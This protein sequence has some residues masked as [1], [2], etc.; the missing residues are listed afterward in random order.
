MIM[1]P[2]CGSEAATQ[3]YIGTR[4]LIFYFPMTTVEGRDKERSP[5][6][7]VLLTPSKSFRHCS[8]LI[9]KGYVRGVVESEKHVRNF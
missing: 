5:L 2:S 7:L 4:V 6:F 3:P 8:M 1:D 9:T